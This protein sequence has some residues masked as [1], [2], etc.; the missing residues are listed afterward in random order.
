MSEYDYMCIMFEYL[1]EEIV[2]Q[3]NPA[4]FQHDRWLYTEIWN[5]MPNLKQSEILQLIVFAGT[6]YPL[7]T[8]QYL[9]LH[10]F[11]NMNPAPFYSHWY[12]MI[13]V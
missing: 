9:V 11:G 5:G 2:D 6:Y 3:Y 4:V 10:I 7:V 8:T 13:V 12:Y 1:L